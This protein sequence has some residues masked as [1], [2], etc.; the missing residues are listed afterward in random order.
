MV[1]VLLL[2]AA[3]AHA[4]DLSVV[5]SWSLTLDSSDLFAGTGTDLRTPIESSGA[6]AMADIYNTGGTNWAVNVRKN[7]VTWPT[8][9]ALYV[10]RTSSGSGSGTISGGTAYQ[11]VTAV[12]SILFSGSGDRSGVQIQLKLEGLSVQRAPDLYSASLTYTVQ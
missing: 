11:Q 7:D 8:G 9:V 3:W 6:Q 4:V 1:L 5:G 12:D 2:P 10:R